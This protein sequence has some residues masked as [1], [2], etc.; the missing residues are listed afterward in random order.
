MVGVAR[1]LG[2]RILLDRWLVPGAMRSARSVSLPKPGLPPWTNE[3]ASSIAY[4]AV[5]SPIRFTPG[6]NAI[7]V[8]EVLVAPPVVTD[9]VLGPPVVT[10]S[11]RL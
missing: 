4:V 1:I 5:L 9:T 10:D 8:G 6:T 2:S 7:A 11:D 3:V